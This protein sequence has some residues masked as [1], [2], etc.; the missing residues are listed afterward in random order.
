MVLSLSRVWPASVG[1]PRFEVVRLPGCRQAITPQVRWFLMLRRAMV[2]LLG[3]KL[4]LGAGRP[5][6]LPVERYCEGHAFQEAFLADP[7]RIRVALLG[8]RTGKT[9]VFA[10]AAVRGAQQG[11]S[12]QWV[13]YI[14][15]TRRNAKRQVWPWIKRI[16]RESGIA[17]KINES[18]LVV[19]L[20]GAG[21][22]MLGGAD[23]T[24]EIEKYRGFPFIGAIVDEC[25]IYPS[26][27]LRTLK[28]DIIEP[29]TLDTGGWQVY[30][31]TPGYVLAGTWYEMSGPH[32]VSSANCG[33][34]RG[35]LFGNPHL[36]SDLPP[37]DRAAAIEAFLA[38]VREENGWS[39]DHPTYVR[40]WRGRWAQDDEAL[41]FPL[42]ANGNDYHGGEDGPWG[43]PSST[44]TGFPLPLSD[45]RVVIGMDVG[46][47]ESNAYVVAATHPSIK[48]SFVLE[49]RKANQQLIEAAEVELRALRS[50]YATTRGGTTHYPTI[51]I[52]SGG[53]GKI[54]A[55]T[56]RQR[57]GLPTEAADKRNKGSSISVTRDDL[58]SGRLALRRTDPTTGEDP[59][60]LLVDEW[61]VLTWNKTRDG[62]ADGQEDHATDAALYALR[63]LRDYTRHEP[64]PG[65]ARGSDEWYREEE[66]KHFEAAKRRAKGKRT[67]GKRVA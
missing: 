55:E 36:R 11:Q 38:E 41:V 13:V 58:L 18:D 32:A 6:P 30:G 33:V 34:Y 62:I 4:A 63:A 54:H 67:K 64:E 44:T 14:T 57:M 56:L 7:R 17:H 39:E 27:L 1:D 10:V 37:E 21:G 47:T 51:V 61:H 19:E 50:K 65:P 49:V 46:Y 42:S 66:A 53:M 23:D 16:L 28:V 35:D 25:G 5:D 26:D 52:D 48:R 43:L 15:R 20:E 45:W 9:V 24:A 12:G 8:R 31:G 60:R 40:E 22:I 59:C 2:G 3:L 29:A